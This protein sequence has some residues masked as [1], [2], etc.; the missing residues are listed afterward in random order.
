MKAD[1]ISDLLS[2]TEAERIQLAQDLW[3][4]IPET[5]A[6]VPLTDAQ[7]A[8]LERRLAAHASDPDSSIS[9]EVARER[10]RQRFGA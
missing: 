9:W 8:E 6:A 2:L 10:L 5:S 7:R 4:S 3:D 1:M